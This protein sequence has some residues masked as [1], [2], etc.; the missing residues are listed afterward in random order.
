[1]NDQAAVLLKARAFDL[2]EKRGAM[3]Q[4]AQALNQELAQIVKELNEKKESDE[5]G[6]SGFDKRNNSK[7][8]KLEKR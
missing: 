2:I 1:M 4:T 7:N 6:G 5:S 3:E 8:P